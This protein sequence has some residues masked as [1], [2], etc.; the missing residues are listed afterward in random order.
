MTTRKT[1]RRKRASVC[2]KEMPLSQAEASAV[3][4]NGDTTTVGS[5]MARHRAAP[6]RR[7]WCCSSAPVVVPV[8]WQPG[9]ELV[10]ALTKVAHQVSAEELVSGRQRGIYQARCGV[11]FLAA[12]MVEPGRSRCPGCVP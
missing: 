4:V 1:P 6:H 2:G 8:L 10:D 7:R 3:M 9:I 5:A 11:R 12:S